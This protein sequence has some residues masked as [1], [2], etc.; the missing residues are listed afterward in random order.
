MMQRL[1]TSFY[2]TM[3]EFARDVELVFSNCRLFNPPTTYPVECANIVEKVFKKEWSKLMERKL[4]WPDKRSLQGL[5][6]NLV[7]EA[8]FVFLCLCGPWN[9]LIADADHSFSEIL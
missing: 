5:M 3:E 9:I 8:M 7:K 4:P 1:N 6:T 2:T